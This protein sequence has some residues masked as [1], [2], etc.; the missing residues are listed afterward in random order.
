MPLSLSSIITCELY[1][2]DSQKACTVQRLQC[3][4]CTCMKGEPA[5]MSCYDL[6]TRDSATSIGT[7]VKK[8]N[9]KRVHLNIKL[10][11]ARVYMGAQIIF[12]P[13]Q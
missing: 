11:K 4:L 1:R 10:T 13:L 9:K 3:K 2:H 12:F 5:S 8:V 7:P 6:W